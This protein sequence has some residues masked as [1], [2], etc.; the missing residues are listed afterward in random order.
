MYRARAE[1]KVKKRS[2]S[3]YDCHT[4]RE[5]AE[6]RSRNQAEEY[7]IVKETNSTI[8]ADNSEH[9]EHI[10]EL[11]GIKARHLS[12]RIVNSMSQH[13]THT[14]CSGATISVMAV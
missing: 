10:E 11:R 3:P 12:S 7:V 14:I 4:G 5:R 6:E 1:N 13:Y 8:E 9:R 2:R